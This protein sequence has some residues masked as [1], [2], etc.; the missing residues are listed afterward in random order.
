MEC[1]WN[2]D[3]PWFS[4]GEQDFPLGAKATSY[5]P[6]ATELDI[7]N[8]TCELPDW[9]E[10]RE[11]LGLP[12]VG[13]LNDIKFPEHME[14]DI[15]DKA[16]NAFM[17][18]DD[19]YSHAIRPEDMLVPL[20]ELE[21]ENYA[22]RGIGAPT[23]SAVPS[24]PKVAVRVNKV[25]VAIPKQ[26]VTPG[27]SLVQAPLQFDDTAPP[28]FDA[29]QLLNSSCQSSRTVQP[30]GEVP[31]CNTDELLN[32]LV[33]LATREPNGLANLITSFD[34]SLIQAGMDDL[35]SQ[36]ESDD[37]NQ[38]MVVVSECTVEP[39]S[40]PIK[41]LSPVSVPSPVPSVGSLSPQSTGE[42]SFHQSSPLHITTD[43]SHVEN[44][45]GA[46]LSL[47][48]PSSED[49]FSVSSPIVADDEESGS[50]YSKTE[51][52]SYSRS[53]RKSKANRK[54]PYPEGRKERKKEQNK[55][56]ALRYRQKK[57]QEDDEF[58]GK[59]QEEEERQKQLKAKYTNLKQELT[60]LKKIMREV[61]IA[62]GTVSPDAFKKK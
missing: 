36:L 23:L 28:Q 14:F 13:L 35:L 19:D 6:S 60:Y 4:G 30:I 16:N 54:S 43:S 5:L 49:N 61:L 37:T 27:H 7:K 46:F 21:P 48:S 59:I 29:M 18:T 44:Y 58:M 39:L 56:A 52:H 12:S 45:E 51:M 8:D 15:K 40:C 38:K 53:P 31:N 57:K 2:S 47:L 10:S 34:S 3:L 33:D 50:D 25:K 20:S 55:Q 26:K 22:P 62:K 41:P 32:E 17:D 42:C 1:N 9:M 11:I 24:I